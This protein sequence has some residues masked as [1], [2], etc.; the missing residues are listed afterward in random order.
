MRAPWIAVLAVACAASGCSAAG[1][2]GH[3]A[4]A[5]ERRAIVVSIDGLMPAV[6]TAPDAHGLAVP[7]LRA[8]VRGGAWARSARSVMPAV[9]YPAH[10]TMATGVEPGAHGI[11]GNRA[12]DPLERNK[13]GWRWYAE[14]IRAPALWDAVEASG[15]TAALVSW[16]VTVGARASFLVPEYWRAGTPEDQKLLR[17]LSTPGLLERVEAR[18]P[19]LWRRLT[20]PNV[21]DEASVD[22]AVHLIETAAPDLIMIHIWMVDEN[23]HVGGPWSPRA[24]AAIENADRQLARLIAACRRR[25]VWDQTALFVV[26]DHGFATAHT[27]VSLA[28]LLRERGLIA[29]GPGGVLASWRAAV[30]S[31]GGTAYI[32]LADPGD[33]EAARMVRELLATL[34][35]GPDAVV[36]RIL[37]PPAIRAL[38]GDPTAALAVEAADGFVFADG[39]GLPWRRPATSPGQHGYAPDRESMRASFLAYG[40]GVRAAELGDVSLTDV[41]PTVAGWLGLRMPRAAGRAIGLAAATR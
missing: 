9:T 40:P 21:S 24:R 35:T 28:A 30:Q 26:S 1:G 29:A 27:V 11:V 18:F 13:E 15:R 34:S 32:Y 25:G 37:E 33:A 20:P 31:N 8:M 7:T 2:A 36:R 22:V 39:V 23:Q 12:F 41:A 14:D 3:G 5:G 16:P 17:A 19:D 6:Y 10:T 4:P 38:G